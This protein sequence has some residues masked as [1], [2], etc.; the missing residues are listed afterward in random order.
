MF[1]ASNQSGTAVG[2]SSML[3][4]ASVLSLSACMA[5][6]AVNEAY[7]MAQSYRHVEVELPLSELVELKERR[8]SSDDNYYCENGD[9]SEKAFFTWR[10]KCGDKIALTQAEVD[11]V[12]GMH[13]SLQRSKASISAADVIHGSSVRSDGSCDSASTPIATFFCASC[14]VVLLIV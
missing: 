1:T 10:C 11:Q 7:E 8:T 14:S 6:R 12:I 9:N 5:V 13:S 4:H 2:V 3:F